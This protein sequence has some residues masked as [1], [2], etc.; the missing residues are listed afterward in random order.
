MHSP[1]FALRLLATARFAWGCACETP[2]SRPRVKKF[3][4]APQKIAYHTRTAP[5]FCAGFFVRRR[6]AAALAFPGL[7]GDGREP[8]IHGDYITIFLKNISQGFPIGLAWYLSN[9]ILGDWPCLNIHHASSTEG[10]PGSW[11][12]VQND[13]GGVCL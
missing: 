12:A 3:W 11:E 13:F 10:T 5:S 1:A 7:L 4:S 2:T 8:S 9:Q 6:C